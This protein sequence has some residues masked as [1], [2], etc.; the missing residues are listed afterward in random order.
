[1]FEKIEEMKW[2]VS[3]GYFETIKSSTNKIK[4]YFKDENEI[5]IGK[6]YTG[7]IKIILNEADI[8]SIV[9]RKYY[10]FD[11]NHLAIQSQIGALVFI[12]DINLN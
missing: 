12:L 1:M 10:L 4:G 2:I 9:M 5:T 8:N 11:K 7:E 3:K 6:K